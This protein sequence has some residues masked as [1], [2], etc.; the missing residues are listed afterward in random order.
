[1]GPPP[2]RRA[3]ALARRA[4]WQ[5]VQDL[6]LSET[7]TVQIPVPTQQPSFSQNINKLCSKWI[8]LFPSQ[9][10]HATTIA[11]FSF[12]CTGNDYLLG[13][14]VPQTIL[15]HWLLELHIIMH[16]VCGLCEPSLFK[17]NTFGY[18]FKCWL[19]TYPATQCDSLY[20]W[21]KGEQKQNKDTYRISFNQLVRIKIKYKTEAYNT[22]LN[23]DF[24]VN[25]K[26]KQLT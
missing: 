24:A 25:C 11:M 22:I 3:L 9:L 1:M 6:I 5:V 15:P 16:I 7:V 8:I 18:G 19:C 12:H 4:D 23:E 2:V 20:I 14:C 13:F 17:F 10:G 21:I 26:Y